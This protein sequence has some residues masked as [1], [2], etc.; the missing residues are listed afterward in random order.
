V[1]ALAETSTEGTYHE[2]MAGFERQLIASTL[3]Q[4]HGD[5]RE[6]ARKLGISLATLY[7]RIDRLALGEG[8]EVTDATDHRAE[9]PRP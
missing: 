4:H 1:G 6:T 9:E 5:R 3:R 7:R 2:S 8:A